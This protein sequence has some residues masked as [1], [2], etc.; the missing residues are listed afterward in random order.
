MPCRCA[1]PTYFALG[2]E[3]QAHVTSTLMLQHMLAV[4]AVILHWG[5]AASAPLLCHTLLF[6]HGLATLPFI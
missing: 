2:N 4:H 6:P 5:H 3:M 1:L